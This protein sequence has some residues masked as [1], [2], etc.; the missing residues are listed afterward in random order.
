M[1]LEAEIANAGAHF[2]T[3]TERVPQL[4]WLSHDGGDWTWASSRWTEYTGQTAEESLG[5]GWYAAVHPDDRAATQA[6]WEQAMRSGVLDVDHRLLNVDRPAEPRWFHTHGM[7]LPAV[8][9][10]EQGWLGFATDVHDAKVKEERQSLLIDEMRYRVGSILALTRSIARRTV[11]ESGTVEDYILHLDGRLDALARTHVMMVANPQAGV[12]LDHLVADALRVHA[13]REGEQVRIAGPA[14]L[15][16]DKAAEWLGLVIHELAMNAVEHGALF[17]PG[18]R[19]F[20]TWRVEATEAGDALRFEWL[21]EN[22]PMPASTPQRSGFG[23]DLIK[24]VLSRELGT[25][26]SLAFS[27]HGVRWT[28][29]VPVAAGVAALEGPHPDLGTSDFEPASPNPGQGGAG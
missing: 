29:S 20:V 10:Q 16:R 25:A 8:E 1:Q 18:G 26:A 2:V 3:L 13:A 19:I 7:P 14:L 5:S 27:P 24:R 21:E 6:A 15:L 17:V 11:R 4:V 9:G 22:V 28:I 23:T 12:G